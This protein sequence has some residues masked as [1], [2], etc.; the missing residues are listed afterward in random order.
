[1]SK[2]RFSRPSPAFVI[3]CI[4]LFVALGGTGYAAIT[5]KRNSVATK[6]LK[7]NAVTSP[8]IRDRTIL[9][10][11][12]A[13]GTQVS[14][15]G[16]KGDTGERGAK[17]DTGEK[18]DKGNACLASDPACRGPQGP[19][20]D[21]ATRLF[22]VVDGATANVIHSSPG[23]TAFDLGTGTYQVNF[24]Q[25]VNQCA[26][27]ASIGGYPHPMGGGL[28]TASIEGGIR[29]STTASGALQNGVLSER[30][31]TVRTFNLSGTDTDT[32]F[33]LALFC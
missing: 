31:I 22:A 27:V 26:A 17:G 15:R 9:I 16:D 7:R 6:H 5:L 13:P 18:G 28:S 10:R 11:D 29:A 14:L 30:L 21:P 8:K 23:V 33:H 25:A 2:L 19:Q 32:S 1:V 4:A 3:A 24:P 20:G 12:L